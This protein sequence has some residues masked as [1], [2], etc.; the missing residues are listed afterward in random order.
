MSNIHTQTSQTTESKELVFASWCSTT[1]TSIWWKLYNE[2]SKDSKNKTPFFSG[3]CIYFFF[4][5]TFLVVFNTYKMAQVALNWC[6]V[7]I[8][9]PLVQ[10]KIY[11]TFVYLIH[12]FQSRE[13]TRPFFFLHF[14]VNVCHRSKWFNFDSRQVIMMKLFQH[15]MCGYHWLQMATARGFQK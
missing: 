12:N 1:K 9:T 6:Y 15:K 13:C 3:K 7:S 10:Y 11:I 5:S 14:D 2:V 8:N 4:L